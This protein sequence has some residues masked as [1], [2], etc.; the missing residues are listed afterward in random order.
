[1]AD[2]MK[3]FSAKA[4]LAATVLAL[5]AQS[6]TG[7]E[8]LP[9]TK[10]LPMSEFQ[11]R[12]QDASSYDFDAPPKGL[13]R[14]ITMAENFDEE[15]G[16]RRTHEIVPVRPTERFSENTQA[17][18]I[19]FSLHQHYQAFT[20]FGRCMPESVTGLPPNTVVTEDAMHIALE[21]ES[22]YLKLFPPA[23]GWKAGRY[24]VEIHTGEQVNEMSLIGTM[25][26]EIIAS[27]K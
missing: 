18:F 19:V 21:D 14:S 5:S 8:E 15:L 23:G 16:F 20:I 1:M 24:K 3:R 11:N 26:F 9:L 4:I 25:R 7:S 2:F 17:V 27:D 13:F 6:S 10:N 12:S 22:G